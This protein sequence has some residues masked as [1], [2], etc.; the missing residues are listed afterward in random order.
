MNLLNVRCD[1]LTPEKA[2]NES[3]ELLKKAAKATIYYL[4]LDCLYK[5][6]K[7]KEYKCKFP[8]YK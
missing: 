4:N 6:Q 2:L 1:N 8:V 5:A 3:L 7:S